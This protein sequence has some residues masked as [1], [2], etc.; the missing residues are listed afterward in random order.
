MSKATDD[1]TDGDREYRMI[2]AAVEETER[3]RWFL[4]EFARRNRENETA[5]L[6]E[7]V[8]KLY[9]AARDTAASARFAFIYHDLHEL[10][11]TIDKARMDLA[12]TGEEGKP[13]PVHRADEVLE[14]S[15]RTGA[16]MQ[17][18]A[19]R[20]QQIAEELREQG[21][22][23]DL[24]DELASHAAGV[25]MAA[26]FQDLTSAR[27]AT[28]IKTMRDMEEHVSRILSRFEEEA[29]RS[30]SGSDIH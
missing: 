15:K 6:T 16:D 10:W 30:G 19:E 14:S 9:R 5:R 22:E 8:E 25:Y 1:K 3:G 12:E 7:A 21:T 29:E 24:C 26:S 2:E 28:V 4:R 11:R 20:L 13:D 27:L 23:D 18:A 17:G